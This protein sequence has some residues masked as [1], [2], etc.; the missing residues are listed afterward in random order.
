MENNSK[1][2]VSS[3]SKIITTI[4]ILAFIIRLVYI[5]K[6]PYMENQHDVEPNGNGLSYIF[7]IYNTGKLPDNNSGQYYHP[8]LH[9]ILAAGYLRIIGIFTEDTEIMSESLQFLTL[10][11]SM[12]L[13]IISYKILEELKIE[14]KYKILLMIVFAFHPTF[15]ILSGTLNNDILCL[16]LM[17]WSILRLIKWY[18]NPDIKN[19]IL[20]AVIIGLS[21]MTK[22]SSGLIAL[23]TI[24][25]FLLRMI[26]DIKSSD[27]KKLVFKKYMYLYMFF[28]CIS[29]PIGLWYPIRNYIKFGQ[30]ILYIMD[31]NNPDLYVGDNSLFS[32]LSLFSS[33]IFKMYGDPWIDFNIPTFLVKSSLFE[34][35]TWGMSFGIIYH[36]AIILNIIMILTFLIS[37][38]YC[39]IKK[40]KKDA[41]WKIALAILLIFNI[42]SYLIMNLK[43]PYGCSMNFRY[44]LIT[45]F[46]GALFVYF[47]LECYRRNNPKLEKVIYKMIFL[48]SVMLC[49]TSNVI[50]LFS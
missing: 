15:T 35:Y 2:K 24:Y 14:D 29:L 3:L 43:L 21:V 12:T 47:A 11:Y 13:I 1:K 10:V 22:T 36:I 27:K 37:I 8:P 4:I 42:I 9:Q 38:V 19:T 5:I 28:G 31:V 40:D 32:R 34:E 7:T 30:P 23:P 48:G 25:I 20:L 41:E 18:S 50:I 26:K 17:T 46:S 33:E 44:L 16:L 49:M 45:I 39:L 6:T